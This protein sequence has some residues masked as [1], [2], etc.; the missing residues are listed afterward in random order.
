[1]ILCFGAAKNMFYTLDSYSV[2]SRSIECKSQNHK[3]GRISSAYRV[4]N[5]SALCKE[6]IWCFLQLF[7]AF[8]DIS[9]LIS[10]SVLCDSVLVERPQKIVPLINQGPDESAFTKKRTYNTAIVTTL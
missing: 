2:L 10:D 4:E 7:C 6:N 1:M 5:Y 9:A 8:I 3:K